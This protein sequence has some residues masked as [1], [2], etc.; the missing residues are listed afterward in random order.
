[1][2]KLGITSD[3]KMEVYSMVAAC[4]LI[5]EIKFGERSGLDMSYVDGKAEIDAVTKLLGVKSSRLNEALTSPSIKVGENVIRKNQ[6]MQKTVFSAAALAKVLYERIF[7]WLLDKCNEAISENTSMSE[8][9][10]QILLYF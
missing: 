8:L 7:R 3:E 2:D 6:N 4:L 1:M 9:P 10:S 5:G